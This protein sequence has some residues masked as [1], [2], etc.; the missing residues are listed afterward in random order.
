MDA[1]ITRTAAKPAAVAPAVAI[2]AWELSET[3]GN[4]AERLRRDKRYEELPGLLLLLETSLEESMRSQS[5]YSLHFSVHERRLFRP[6]RQDGG[7]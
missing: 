5:P 4:F 2:A 1:A 6:R 3:L 7:P